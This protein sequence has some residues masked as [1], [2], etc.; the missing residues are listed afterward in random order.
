MGSVLSKAAVT[1]L[2][3]QWALFLVAAYFKTEKFYDLAGSATFILLGAQSL[4]NTGKYF[5]RQVQ[6]YWEAV[7]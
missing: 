6:L 4:M 1:D 5:P 7:I 2:A 3:L